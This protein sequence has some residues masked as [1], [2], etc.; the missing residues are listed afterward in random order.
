MAVDTGAMK[1]ITISIAIGRFLM[2]C[3]GF[4]WR[5]LLSSAVMI[6][7][8]VSDEV[9]AMRFVIKLSPSSEVAI[10]HQQYH[11]LSSSTHKLT[12]V[13]EI[14]GMVKGNRVRRRCVNAKPSL[15]SRRVHGCVK[16]TSVVGKIPI[17]Q[18]TLGIRRLGGATRTGQHLSSVIWI[19]NT[20]MISAY[21]VSC[22]GLENCPWGP[23]ICDPNN[24]ATPVDSSGGISSP[25][26]YL[27]VS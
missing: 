15:T 17:L 13:G 10:E 27:Y 2:S 1:T 6:L 25:T 14:S 4:T 11:P 12:C 8:W 3:S 5:I 24:D 18:D 22:I 9:F 20:H 16:R 21:S 26:G 19:G 23:R 7:A